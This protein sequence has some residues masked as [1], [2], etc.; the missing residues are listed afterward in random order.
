M[1]PGAEGILSFKGNTAKI[2]NIKN[3]NSSGGDPLKLT[4]QTK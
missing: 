3:A 1:K 2:E 4:K